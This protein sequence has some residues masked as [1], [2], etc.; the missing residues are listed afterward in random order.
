MKLYKSIITSA[1]VTL[2]GVMTTGC[3]D[4]LNYTPKDKQTYDQQFSTVSGF[5]TAANGAYTALTYSSLYGYNLSY[6]PIDVMANCYKISEKNQGMLE[7]LTAS[8][9][10]NGPVGV[11]NGIWTAAYSNILNINVV[12]NALE[13]YPDVLLPDE[14]ELIKAEM[15]AMR[16][17][18]HLD[19]T[20]LFG[21]SYSEKASVNGSGLAVPF[22]GEP[23][24]IKR[25]RLS[26][27]SI[28]IN[29]ILPDLTVAQDI[30]KELDP[31]FD[32]GVL[33]T[34]ADIEDIN[35]NWMR[36]RNLRLN[37]YAVSLL[38]ARAYMWMNDY[39]NALAE[40]RA[41]VDDPLMS[42]LFEWVNPSRVLANNTNPDRIFS[43]E[44]F[45]GYYRSDIQSIYKTLF[46]GS[47]DIDVVLQPASGR[48]AAL[49]TNAGDYRRQVQWATSTG[50]NSDME[51]VKYKGFTPL[52]D[53]NPEFYATYYGLL[54][55]SEAYLIVAESAAKLGDAA[56]ALEY[57]NIFRQKRGE[58]KM[59]ASSSAADIAKE[60][61]YEYVR[62]FRGEGQIFFNHKRNME[63]FGL[64]DGIEMFQH[65][66]FDGSGTHVSALM[67]KPLPEVRYFPPI[68][69]SE[70]Y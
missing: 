25:D 52:D 70:N 3:N 20:R 16:A 18:L 21:P 48:T 19:L 58:T 10:S 60:V 57:M 59:V 53:E 41:I 28:I 40:A 46:A 29:H 22:A 17:Y 35:G 6:G 37:Y 30:L 11:L 44:C 27:D 9:S 63:G 15:L 61:R 64:G 2:A 45:F 38:K 69:V 26:A 13:Q 67:S 8:Y 43:T 4:W 68:P 14:H 51:F 65:S 34:P 24:I 66:P 36:Y 54:R 50:I 39:K 33:N 56:T 1:A 47:L 55:K 32:G 62:E 31:I 7:L 49:Y 42:E 12:L 23:K 5:R